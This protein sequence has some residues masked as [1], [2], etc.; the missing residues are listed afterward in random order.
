MSFEI[1]TLLQMSLKKNETNIN[2]LR[3]TQIL[4]ERKKLAFELH[5]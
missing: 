4:S 1:C 2:L 5:I 3:Y